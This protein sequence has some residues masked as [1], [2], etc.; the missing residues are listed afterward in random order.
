MSG[1]NLAYVHLSLNHVPTIGFAVALGIFLVA[2]FG[3]SD[4]LKRTSF[5]V[6]FLIAL[7][8]IPTYLSGNAA[9]EAI[10]NQ[11]GVSVPLVHAHESAAM[12]ALLFMELTGLAAWFGLWQYRRISRLPGWNVAC[13]LLLALVTF[14]FM[15]NAANIGG[16]IRHPEIQ[17][18]QAGPGEPAPGKAWVVSLG[19]WVIAKS[20]VWPACESVHFIGL[21]LLFS[22]VVV[23]DLRMLG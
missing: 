3:E 19:E 13:V 15:T 14:G 9:F 6:F 5:V 2:L 8:S 16:Q 23:V 4:A 17:A 20:W 11:P 12:V 10:Q 18:V 7:L 1:A 22:V 21:C